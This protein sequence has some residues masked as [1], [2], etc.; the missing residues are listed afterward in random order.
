[1]PPLLIKYSDE[2]SSPYGSLHEQAMEAW[3]KSKL[4]GLRMSNYRILHNC[5]VI[6]IK[7]QLETMTESDELVSD[8]VSTKGMLSLLDAGLLSLQCL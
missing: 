5:F 1:M 3:R 6:R 2:T 8:S 7:M 4:K